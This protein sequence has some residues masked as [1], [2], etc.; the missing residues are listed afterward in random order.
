MNQ[1]YIAEHIKRTNR[2]FVILTLLILAISVWLL[3]SGPVMLLYI[4]AAFFLFSMVLIFKLLIRLFNVE[5]HPIFK[6]VSFYGQFDECSQYINS[7]VLNVGTKKYKD[8]LITDRWLLQSAI[9]KLNVLKISDVVWAYESIIKHKQ[10]LLGVGVS[11]LP[12]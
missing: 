9:F 5:N 7:E 2:N 3:F 8:L 6:A 12:T 10:T 4:G 11:T 1:D